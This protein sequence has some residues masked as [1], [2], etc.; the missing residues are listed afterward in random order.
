MHNKNCISARH[1][2]MQFLLC[3]YRALFISFMHKESLAISHLYWFFKYSLQYSVMS[4]SNIMRF[5]WTAVWIF[6]H[7]VWKRSVVFFI[8]LKIYLCNFWHI[9]GNFFLYF[10]V[11]W[12][13]GMIYAKNNKNIFK[14]I[15]FVHKI[16]FFRKYGLRAKWHCAAQWLSYSVTLNTAYLLQTAV[17]NE[18]FKLSLLVLWFLNL[19]SCTNW[20]VSYFLLN[21]ALHSQFLWPVIAVK[22]DR[23]EAESEDGVVIHSARPPSCINNHVRLDTCVIGLVC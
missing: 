22:S 1:L 14:I 21:F 2:Y 15:Q 9:G 17:C 7:C 8:W 11:K 23:S 3:I 18:F 4:L 10:V 20:S 13:T 12:I 6:V 5:W 16:L 19:S